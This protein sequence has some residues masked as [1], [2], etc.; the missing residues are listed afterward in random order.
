MSVFAA[1]RR[2]V[3]LEGHVDTSVRRLS[4]D[5]RR[6]GNTARK[7]GEPWQKTLKF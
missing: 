6:T 3:W 1:A 4:E 2:P 5:V 7:S